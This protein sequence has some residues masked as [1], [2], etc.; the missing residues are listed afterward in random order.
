ML[1]DILVDSGEKMEKAPL[2]GVAS[3][4]RPTFGWGSADEQILTRVESEV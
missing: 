1:D 2:G 3:V 4:Y